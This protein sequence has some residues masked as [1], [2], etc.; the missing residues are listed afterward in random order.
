MDKIKNAWAAYVM[1]IEHYPTVAAITFP[2]LIVLA[3]IVF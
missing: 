3:A 1:A 2:V